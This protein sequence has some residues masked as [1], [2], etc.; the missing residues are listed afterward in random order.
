MFRRWC[1]RFSRRLEVG[2]K[3]APPIYY[4]EYASLSMIEGNLLPL[5]WHNILCLKPFR[6][7]SLVGQSVLSFYLA[8]LPFNNP[9]AVRRFTISRYLEPVKPP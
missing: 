6:L 4:F 2:F 8:A 7:F 1:H 5:Y 3:V 9:L